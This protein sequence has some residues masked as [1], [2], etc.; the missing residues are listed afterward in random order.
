VRKVLD[1]VG[2]A[3]Q[4]IDR[5]KGRDLAREHYPSRMRPR[6]RHA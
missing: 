6:A 3:W 5:A 4:P 1:A 2:K